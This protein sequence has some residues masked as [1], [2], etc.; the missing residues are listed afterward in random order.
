[1]G[2]HLDAKNQRC[3]MLNGDGGENRCQNFIP[4]FL[5]YFFGNDTCQVRNGFPGCPDLLTTSEYII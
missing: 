4:D 3:K 2:S 1:M 5:H